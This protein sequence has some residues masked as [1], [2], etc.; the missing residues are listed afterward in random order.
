VSGRTAAPVTTVATVAT[1]S[2]TT[3]MIVLSLLI[4]TGRSS[5]L[6]R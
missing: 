3:D 5:L 6:C 1:V 4:F 2:A